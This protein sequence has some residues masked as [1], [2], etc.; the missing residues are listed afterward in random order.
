MHGGVVGGSTDLEKRLLE[1]DMLTLIVAFNSWWYWTYQLENPSCFIIVFNRRMYH[2]LL[3]LFW[4][5]RD[6]WTAV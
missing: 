2:I 4:S 5:V 6:P 1:R 3:H